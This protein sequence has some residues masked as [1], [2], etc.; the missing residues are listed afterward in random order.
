M[1]L[2]NTLTRQKED[3]TPIV[4]GKVG[5]YSCGPTVYNFVHLGNLRT[6]IMSDVLKRVLR[7]NGYEVNHIMNITD[8]GHLVVEEN[9]SGQDK[10]ER[11]ATE[12]GKTV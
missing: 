2:F 11:T 12:Q 8:V 3:F 1:K 6:Y 9:D 7:I 10:M 4:E 5:M